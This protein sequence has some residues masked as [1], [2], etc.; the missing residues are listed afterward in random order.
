MF[1][2]KECYLCGGKLIDGRCSSCGLDNTKLEKKNYRLNESSF[3]RKK[4][5]TYSQKRQNETGETKKR[6]KKQDAG[7][8]CESHNGRKRTQTEYQQK[9]NPR[10]EIPQTGQMQLGGPT[11]FNPARKVHAGSYEEQKKA[12]KISGILAGI[13]VAIV[14]FTSIAGSV[15]DFISSF[16]DDFHSSDYDWNDD[17][18]EVDSEYDPYMN[19]T[20]ELSETG[21]TYDCVL[22][23]GEYEIGAQ[24]PE[25][26]YEVELVSGEGSMQQDDPE[27]S[28]YYYSY[29]SEDE[30]DTDAGDY[31]D[32]VRLYT[33]G[34]L[35]IDTGLVVQF[36]SCKGKGSTPMTK[37]I[38]LAA[39]HGG[40]E[41][42]EAVKAHLDELGLEYIDFGTHSTASVDY[43]DMALPAC[44]AV[45]SGQCSK[46]LLF[47]G[48][49][50]GISMAANKVKGI[51]ACCCSD[52]FSCE[53]TR[54]HNDANAL[55]MGG[56]VVGPGLAC[57]L[58]DIFLNTEFEGG[59]HEKR[60]AKLM[61]IENR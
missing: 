23:Y 33:G 47:C 42:K 7:H 17:G 58:V 53:Y 40:F 13:I 2:K 35:K 6:E 32:D 59:R 3:D 18:S 9:E 43:P 11:V 28:I 50:V 36:H 44:D 61:A 21:A 52:S 55:C 26:T 14:A 49:G 30:S 39:D 12:R 5:M 29:F 38:A 54:R 4:K 34:H 22:G 46:A 16:G 31:L 57:Q 27:N 48:T 60:I 8:L 24:I 37:P 45:V 15:G 20:R 19:T 41:L 56:R 25:G 10:M 1:K 51:R